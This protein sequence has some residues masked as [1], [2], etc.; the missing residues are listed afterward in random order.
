MTGDNDQ[1]RPLKKHKQH[2]KYHHHGGG[3]ARP[4]NGLDLMNPGC[5]R[6]G[7]PATYFSDAAVAG[8]Y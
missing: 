4:S 1:T 6:G 3:S 5:W 7:Q 2:Y 8:F